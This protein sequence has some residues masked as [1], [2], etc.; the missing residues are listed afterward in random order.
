MLTAFVCTRTRVVGVAQTP[1]PWLGEI[2]LRV[3]LPEAI[4]DWGRV[5]VPVPI[6]T[7]AGPGTALTFPLELDLSKG[8]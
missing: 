5:E 8:K 7:R 6:A 2:T 4:K 1:F 3:D